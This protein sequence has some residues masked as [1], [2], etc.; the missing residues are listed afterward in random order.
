MVSVAVACQEAGSAV[1]CSQALARIVVGYSALGLDPEQERVPGGEAEAGID[2]GEQV[3][4]GAGLSPDEHLAPGGDV[5]PHPV[6]RAAGLAAEEEVAE[7]VPRGGGGIGEGHLDPQ[8]HV[9]RPTSA[10][11]APPAAVL[12]A[13]VAMVPAAPSTSKLA[14]EPATTVHG[15]PMSAVPHAFETVRENVSWAIGPVGGQ[16]G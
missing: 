14:A 7:E 8:V 13:G 3:G 11:G 10:P 1:P 15:P 6:V 2:V 5:Q 16:E 12:P 9:P 4:P